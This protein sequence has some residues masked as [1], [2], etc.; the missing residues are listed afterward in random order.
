MTEAI[1][2]GRILTMDPGCPEIIDGGLCVRDGRILAVGP[3]KE[4]ACGGAQRDLG[5]V[6]IVPGLINAHTHLELSHLAGLV[7]MGQGFMAWADGLF[8]A[9]RAT[10]CDESAMDRAAQEARSSGTCCVADVVGRELDLVRLVLQRCGLE[11][12]LLREYSGRNRDFDPSDLPGPW[13]PGVHALYSTDSGFSQAVKGWCE[14]RQLPFSLHLAE[15]PGENELFLRGEG[16]FASFLRTRGILPRGFR[17][18]GMSA[19]QFAGELGLLNERTLAVHCVQVDRDDVKIL[20]QSGAF[21]C[22]CPRSNAGIGVGEAPAADL[23][24]AG[25]PLCL[26]TDSLASVQSLDLW[27]E[28][29][30]VRKLLPAALALKDLLPLVTINPA[31][32]LGLW[33]D[34]GSLEVGKRAAWAVLP[35][36]LEEWSLGAKR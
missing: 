31:R 36:D 24:A 8:A 1:R 35:R 14:S 17:A 25:V 18:P 27:E 15:V 7:P 4:V 28:L 34:Y 32:A 2:A 22:L 29:R 16:E 30:A 13:S 9:M 11:G 20:A 6:T 5:P 3:W 26:G 21:V 23:H 12:F 19:V 10:R 33:Q